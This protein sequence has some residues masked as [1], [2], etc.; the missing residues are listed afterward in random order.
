MTGRSDK[1]HL[2]IISGPSGA[3]KGTLRK[4]LFQRVQDL[5]FSVSCTTRSPRQGEI[6]GQDYHFIDED[7]FQD[8][9]DRGQFLEWAEVHGNYYGTLKKD[10]QKVLDEGKDVIL[11]IDVQGAHQVRLNCEQAI[12]IFVAPPSMKELEERLRKRGTEDEKV[13]QVRL[14]NA[15]GELEETSFFD[16]VV[17]NDVFERAV[18]ELEKIIMSYKSRAETLEA[19]L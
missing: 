9:I 7:S 15:R 16:H 12:M 4:V 11:E 17:V 10:I 2:F 3:G 5:V 6:N 19:E 1:G 13:L 14:K 8:L 18:F